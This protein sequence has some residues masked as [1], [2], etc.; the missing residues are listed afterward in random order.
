MRDDSF[1]IGFLEKALS[2]IPLR[3]M[4]DVWCRYNLPALDA[5]REGL[6]EQLRPAINRCR[7]FR[8]SASPLVAGQTLINVVI[9]NLGRN[10]H[11][12]HVPERLADR[13]QMRL[14]LWQATTARKL[15]VLFQFV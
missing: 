12:A 5:E 14:K 3:Q 13:L 4:T 8:R 2:H 11:G 15:V 10:V 9:N 7:R 6:A 1:E